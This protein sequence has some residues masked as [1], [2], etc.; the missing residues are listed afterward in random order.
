MSAPDD[1][2]DLSRVLDALDD[3]DCRA[4]LRALDEPMTANE[5]SEACDVPL[6]TTYRKLE[7]L[8]EATLVAEETEVRPDGRHRSRYRA[9]FDAIEVAFDDEREL[10][11][12]IDR[13]PRGPSERLADIWSEVQRET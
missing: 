13:P 2:P 7:S 3:A 10:T 11:V 5:L 6:S 4:F 8:T 1:D 12:E 9:D